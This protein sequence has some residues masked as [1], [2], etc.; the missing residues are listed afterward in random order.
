MCVCASKRERERERE[1]EECV[2]VCTGVFL[3]CTNLSASKGIM[4]ADNST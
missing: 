2:C 3:C 4:W 1:R